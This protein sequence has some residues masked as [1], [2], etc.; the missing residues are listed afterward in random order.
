VLA[1]LA[2][3]EEVEPQRRIA[4]FDNDGTLWCEKPTYPQ[5]HFWVRELQAAAAAQPALRERPEYRAILEGDRA[6]MAEFGLARVAMALV[7]LFEGM[8]PEEFTVSV[9]RFFAEARHPERGVPFGALVYAPMLELI[10]E[11]R[12]R[13][14]GVF[15]GT[16]GGADF[17]RVVSEQLY[18]V[19][20][21]RVVGSRVTYELLRSDGKLDLCRTAV[22]DGDPNEGPA[23]VP[24]IQRQI[25]RRPMMAAGNSPGDTE[26]LEYAS[27]GEG[28]TLALLVNHDDAER[29]YAYESS[30]G[31]FDQ[32]EP[33]LATAERLGWTVVSMRQ[34]WETVFDT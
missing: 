16:G 33:I 25:G 14:F 8:S 15:I 30:A 31:T 27:T 18:G 6:A 12:A 5:V 21:E 29:E 13:E 32:A 4:I 1:F 7:E 24:N 23:K 22:M 17:V 34:D 20:P 3:A 28:P 10:A 19:A 2:D 11:L 26:M 9:E